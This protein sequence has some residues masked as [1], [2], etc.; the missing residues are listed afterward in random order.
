M[1]DKLTV[2]VTGPTGSAGTG[3]VRACL[4]HPEVGEVRVLTR[5]PTGVTHEKLVEVLHDDFL[6]Y[7]AVEDRL[8]GIDACYWCL[9]VSQSKVRR[10]A[11][12]HRI[13]YE[14]TMEAAKVLERLNPGMT[15]CFLS[16]LGTDETQRSRMMWARIKGKAE[17]DLLRTDLRVFNFRPGFIHPIEGVKSSTVTG[18]LLYPFIKRSKKWCVEADEFGLAMINATLHGYESQT[19]ENADIRRLA[20]MH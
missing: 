14:F 20:T 8:S 17:A 1:G 15:F 2:L 18:I 9:G 7:S 12:Y 11:D 10:E 3:V 5:R 16:G 13:T 19:L 4:D 6:D